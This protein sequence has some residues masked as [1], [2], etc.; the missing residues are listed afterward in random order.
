MNDPRLHA[1]G[2]RIRTLRRAR[3]MSQEQFAE[4]GQ[5]H[6]TFAGA[7]ERGETNISFST[8]GRIADAL[9]VKIEDLFAG[10]EDGKSS[11]IETPS[12]QHSTG[13]DRRRLQK[14]IAVLERAVE[15]L[16]QL[17]DPPRRTKRGK[18]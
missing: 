5:F 6:R 11:R 18:A 7:I 16:K 13:V 9:D 15:A 10:L 4:A 12:L 2:E 3:K 8:L 14:Q 1:L 17:A